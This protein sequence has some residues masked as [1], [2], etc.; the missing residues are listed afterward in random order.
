MASSLFLDFPCT[1]ASPSSPSVV[2]LGWCDIE[3][4]CAVVTDD[5]RIT[6]Y[7]EEGIGLEE[8]KIERHCDAT[9]MAWQPQS[10]LLATG[11]DDGHVATHAVA[12]WTN[13]KKSLAEAATEVTTSCVWS[14]D[15]KHGRCPVRLAMWNSSGNRFVSGDGNGGV[16]VWKAD[17]RG[18]L[19]ALREYVMGSGLTC[20]VFFL[21]SSKESDDLVAQR[22]FVGTKHGGV[23][24]ADDLGK[25][26]ECQSL[27][28]RIDHVLLYEG[29]Q[30]L[31]VLTRGLVL[32]Q[33]QVYD[34]DSSKVVP[35][36]KV[37]VSVAGSHD[38]I[39]NLCW[40]GPGVVVAATGETMIRFWNLSN[41]ETYVVSL[42]TAKLDRA[43]RCVSVAFHAHQRYLAA[44][45]KDG[46][47]AMWR[48]IGGSYH[49]NVRTSAADWEAM[50][51]TA[52]CGGRGAVEKLAFGPGHGLLAAASD[53]GAT[54]ILSETV[55]YRLLNA[56]VGVIQ[57]STEKFRAERQNGATAV[58]TTD[59]SIRGLAASSER[60]VAWNGHEARVY[61]WPTESIGDPKLVSK[62]PTSAKALALYH[63]DTLFRASGSYVELCNLHG[64]VKSKISF[65]EQEGHPHHL[66]LNGNYLAVA[67]D[68]GLV[69]IFQVD[70]R[71]PKQFGSPG[72]FLDDDD[73]DE[74]DDAPKEDEDLALTVQKVSRKEKKKFMTTRAPTAR[75]RVAA[76]K[77]KKPTTTATKPTTREIRSIRCNADGT[78]VSI[79]ADRVHGASVRIRE[80]DPRLYVYDADR[81]VVDSHDFHGVDRTPVSHFWDPVEP[82]LLACETRFAG[83][84][85]A[86]TAKKTKTDEAYSSLGLRGGGSNHKDFVGGGDKQRTDDDGESAPLVEVTTLFVTSDDGMLLQDVFPLEQPLEALVGIQVPRLFFTRSSNKDE[87]GE[88]KTGE[89]KEQTQQ[90][91][92]L[93]SRVMRDFVGLDDA[94]EQT[95]SALLDFSYYLTVGNMD[96]AHKAVRLIKSPGVW[97]NMAHMCVKTKRLD[98]A[99]VCLGNMGHARGSAA[100]RLAKQRAPEL[101]ARVAALAIQLGLRQDAARLY[102]ECG[103]YDLL[104]ELYQ[105]AG[106]WYLA[107]E[108]A[109]THDRIHLKSTHHRYAKHLE[110]QGNYDAAA[111]HFELAETQTR[112]VPRM[113]VA[114]HEQAALER[115]VLKQATDP[116]N[117][118]NDDNKEN[119]DGTELLTWWAGY[120]ESLGHLDS[121]QSC[122]DK[123]N[124]DYNLVRLAC[125]KND[126]KRATALVDQGK[127]KAGAYHLARHLEARGDINDAIQYFA[128]SGCYNHAI[129]LARQYGFDTDL[130]QFCLK[131]RPSLQIDCANY[132][133]QK[134]EYEKAVQLYQKGGEMTKALDLCF[135]VGGKG[136][137]Q[138]FEMLGNISQSLD[139]ST[140]SPE[141]LAKCA[142]FFIEHNQFLQAVKLFVAG[143]RYRQAIDLCVE[144]NVTITTELADDLTPPKQQQKADE[145][146]TSDEPRRKKEILTASERTRILEEL[147]KACKKQGAF[148]LA[149]KK[150]TE[151][152]DRSK[153][154]RCLLKSGDTKSIIYYATTSRNR[155]FYILTANYL[156]SLDW[157]SGTPEATALT[158]KIVEF[159]QKAKAHDKL[160]EFYDAY[161]QVEIDEYRDY[162][163]ALS[164]LHDAKTQLEKAA[165]AGDGDTRRLTLLEQ[166][167]AIVADFVEARSQEKSDPASM[168]SMVNDILKRP[169]VDNAIRIGDAFALLVEYYFHKANQPKEAFD[170][171]EQMRSKNI[172]LHPYIEQ[173]LLDAIHNAVG[174]KLPSSRAVS[175]RSLGQTGDDSNRGLSGDDDDVIPDDLDDDAIPDEID[176]VLEDDDDDDM[177][178]H[179]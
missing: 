78:R 94:D 25:A 86:A 22:F 155:D 64:N 40:A 67:T 46:K 4:I 84:R 44:G 38:G 122:Y 10:K 9:C 74:D 161:A 90:D 142:E 56:D 71:E 62:F 118:K 37:K 123:A 53:T 27:G 95:K 23:Y 99:E 61:E 135:K 106:E 112:E 146:K 2:L 48:F 24:D 12:T 103:R 115:Y 101:E 149:C 76:G 65:S 83:H 63:N 70:R 131:A 116:V 15:Q 114:K 163:K 113:L 88:A 148:Q 26:I 138:I 107:L 139:E 176:E 57:L 125:V 105:A 162:E 81:D 72:Y 54:S 7:L 120:C 50:P 147:A 134:G 130:M 77:K 91:V 172:A 68:K 126:V 171:L 19:T 136:R 117:D 87:A 92:A 119:D 164:A 108:T 168:A 45:T 93:C 41:D 97:E 173:D 170:L 124:D 3:G 21:S 98:V 100:L 80:P 144:R 166:R 75:G 127:S 89:A 111:R 42:T 157:Q 152:G 141:V 85:K 69:K 104:N 109:E 73:D 159:Y 33:L 132:F 153:A 35:V 34:D 30:R 175:N 6:F 14:T 177:F 137:D 150:Y 129:R 13:A 154:L 179:K 20:G 55:L 151:A 51:P 43:A 31:V 32:V 128:K 82:K 178:R 58:V 66:D 36:M 167:I 1:T 169:D 11:W 79:L 39:R 16:V 174:V 47:V 59:I 140:A 18:G 158:K 96:E 29:K 102:K 133:E 17:S 143:G 121:A 52:A 49:E 165:Q 156:Q 5:H 160:A 60:I 145:E 28:A 110:A 8:C